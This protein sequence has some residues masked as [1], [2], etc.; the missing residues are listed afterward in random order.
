MKPSIRTTARR[1][2]VALITVMVVATA[3]VAST[4][5]AAPGGK[6]KLKD[7]IEVRTKKTAAVVVGDTAWVTVSIRGKRDLEDV[8]FT[9]KLKDGAT[10]EYPSNTVDHSGPYNDTQLDK[11]ET[12]YVAFRVT[13]PEGFRKKNAS[14]DLDVSFT[15][16]G[17]SLSGSAKCRFPL[18]ANEHAHKSR[19]PLFPT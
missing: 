4:A 2:V 6:T 7:Y 3:T 13:V 1:F 9:A 17:K 11:K 16:K 12:D 10:V 8:R 19:R 15:H 14:L 5:Q 18:L